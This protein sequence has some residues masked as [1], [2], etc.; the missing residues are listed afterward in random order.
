MSNFSFSGVDYGL[1]DVGNLITPQEDLKPE[2]DLFSY[3]MRYLDEYEVEA[4]ILDKDGTVVWSEFV[5]YLIYKMFLGL[6]YGIK[7]NITRLNSHHYEYD[8][9]PYLMDKLRSLS[10]DRFQL[11]DASRVVNNVAYFLNEMCV[12]LNS[13]LLRPG[14]EK[15]LKLL[16]NRSIPCGMVTLSKSDITRRQLE[17]F[18][19]NQFFQ[20]VIG[21][22]QVDKRKPSPEGFIKMA[23]ILGTK[24]EKTLVI[25]DTLNDY[26]AASLGGFPFI[27]YNEFIDASMFF[28]EDGCL[29]NAQKAFVKQLHGGLPYPKHIVLNPCD[30]KQAFLRN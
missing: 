15:S 12:H 14:V 21:A 23:E 18:N 17:L 11:I 28:K 30:D 5:S 2:C 24:P 4:V 19:I 8:F 20:A 7:D 27:W 16:K 25:G 9:I 26:I 29:W 6:S 22:E 13:L 10:N 1:L 3:L